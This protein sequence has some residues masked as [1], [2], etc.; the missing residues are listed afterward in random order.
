L[1][2]VRRNFEAEYGKPPGS[3]ASLIA[4]GKLGSREMT[5]SSDLDLMLIYDFD[6]ERP[7]SDGPRAVHAV[8]YYTRLTQRL[9]SALTSPT[10]AGRLYEVDMRLRPSGRK[11]PVATQLSAFIAYQESEAETWEHMSLTRARPIAGEATLGEE[12]ADVIARTLMRPRDPATLAR[13]VRE[14]RALIAREKGDADPWDLKLARGGLLDVEFVAQYLT[15]RHASTHPG[16][17]HTATAAVLRH[18]RDGALLEVAA[19]DALIDA[20]K[21]LS[22]VTQL[23]R[24]CVEGRFDPGTAPIGV[25]R[26]IATALGLPDFNALAGDLEARRAEVRACCERILAAP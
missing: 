9:V 15:L 18:A 11:G 1:R 2:Q 20:H 24:L 14:M 13:E 22:D 21:V 7:E 25:K 26:R 23:L 6:A 16:I 3:R 8:Q 4:L 19:A 17:R 12:V 10:R 5:P